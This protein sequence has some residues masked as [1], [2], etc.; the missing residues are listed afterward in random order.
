MSTEYS[1][2]FAELDYALILYFILTLLLILVH[3][4]DSQDTQ[5]VLDFF[6]NNCP[7]SYLL[8]SD[9]SDIID[10]NFVESCSVSPL[11]D[12]TEIDNLTRFIT[13]SAAAYCTNSKTWS[14]GKF[15]DDIPQTTVIKDIVPSLVGFSFDGNEIVVAFR[16]TKSTFDKIIDAL[17]FQ[18]PYY[19]SFSTDISEVISDCSSSSNCDDDEDCLSPSSTCENKHGDRLNSCLTGDLP[20]V[21][22]GFY[23]Y[24]LL[25]Q[26][27]IK[28]EI[29][30]LIKKY[31]NYDV[32]VTGHSLG[33]GL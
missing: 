9:N 29:S 24:Y 3:S 27:E 21:H 2:Y 17:M 13:Y 11:N 14:C 25:V 19:P 6:L 4:Q 1:V 28:N 26:D 10:S 12:K 15:C 31:P 5:D 23:T 32:I 20:C 22:F 33:E 18:I 16:G 30:D 8:R 7:T